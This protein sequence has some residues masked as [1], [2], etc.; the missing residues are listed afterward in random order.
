[1]VDIRYFGPLSCEKEDSQH[2]GR[3]AS[4]NSDLPQYC[5]YFLSTNFKDKLRK[6]IKLCI[7]YVSVLESSNTYLPTYLNTEQNIN[8]PVVQ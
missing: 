3:I 5:S 6:W 1:M 4:W 8:C 7:S 2:D